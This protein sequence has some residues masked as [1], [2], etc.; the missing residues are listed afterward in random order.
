[1]KVERI[2]SYDRFVAVKREWN[3]LLSNSGQNRPF[4][5]HQW[6]D[7]WWQ[8]FGQD[9][10]LE[11]IFFR[12]ESKSLV[13]IAPMMVKNHLLQFIASHEVTDYCDFISCAD[14]RDEFYKHLWDHFQTGSSRHYPMEFIN[15]PASSPTL[16]SL[17]GLAAR[18]YWEHEFYES[19]VAPIL[20][21]PASHDEFLK[22]LG[23]KNRHELR[24]KIRKF[25]S[26]GNVHFERI[27]ETE[28]LGSAIE[29]FVILHK[30]SSFAKQEF[31]RKQGMNEFFYQLV[32]LFAA[33]NWA[34]LLMLYVEDRLIA[35]LLSFSY[36]DT[37]YY[38]NIAY[39]KE[40]SAYSPGFTLFDYSIK[41]AIT[42]GKRVADFL[43]GREKYKYFFGAKESKIYSSKLIPKEQKR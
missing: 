25:K 29:Q 38:Y 19:E 26:L 34:E 5:T 31:W 7:A 27:A 14:R 13:G 17:S 41:K 15:I 33:E 35:V 42:Q 3:T 16:S 18:D 21:L 30:A 1:M 2:T 23:R 43:R 6:F 32:T 36:G 8:S 39:D 12:D 11:I 20:I 40:Y 37:V 24:R 9:S 4:L 10:V 22:N 28:K